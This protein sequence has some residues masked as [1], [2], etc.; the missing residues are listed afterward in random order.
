MYLQA[1]HKSILLIVLTIAFFLW[2]ATYCTAQQNEK[3]QKSWTA[4][5]QAV[6]TNNTAMVKVLTTDCVYCNYC[7]YNT[8]KENQAFVDSMKKNPDGWTYRVTNELQYL[9]VD[10]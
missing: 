4:F 9:P 6:K 7:L 10:M 8:D 5:V 3:F 2:N 1:K